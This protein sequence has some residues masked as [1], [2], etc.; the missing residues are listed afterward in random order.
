MRR[1]KTLIAFTLMLG[2][3]LMSSCKKQ[4]V[5]VPQSSDPVFKAIGT[6]DATQFDLVAGDNNAYMFTSIEDEN[7]VPLYTGKLSDGD[8]SIEIGIYDGLIDMPDHNVLNSLP[9]Q[10]NYSRKT[11]APIAV[12]T[13]ESFPNVDLIHHINWSVDGYIDPNAGDSVLI[14]EPGKYEVCA[15]ILFV[16]GSSDNLCSE[17][18]L[19]YE[20]H[21]NFNIKHF[22]NQ[23]GTLTAWVEDPQVAIE[24]VEW[25]LDNALISTS[26]ELAYSSLP[27]GNH[28]L[29][30]NVF[31]VNGVKRSKTMIVDGNL[32][33]NFIDD[34]SFFEN[35]TLSLLNRDFNVRLK[36]EQDGTTFSS[37][38][39]NNSTNSVTFS[40]VSYYAKD[41]NGNDVYK[42]KAHIVATVFDVQ[43]VN[44]SREL[45]F[46]TTFG[47]A[48]PKD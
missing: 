16:D 44:G 38:I 8:L 23:N 43:N 28:I 39:V 45:E 42:V 11:T 30:A 5:D 40:D 22:L 9:I 3:L 34:L 31:F 13:K 46:D 1:T 47:I 17:L 19:G 29:R 21:A 6:I 18:I 27:G 48:I 2:G 15:H 14:T 35:G 24:K 33:G 4:T 32:T 36:M 7:N 37:D 10:L 20:R 26:S 41:V 12:L 25:L